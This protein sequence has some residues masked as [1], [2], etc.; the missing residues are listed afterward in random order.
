M[1]TPFKTPDGQQPQTAG[2]PQNL[3]LSRTALLSLATAVVV[4]GIVIYIGIRSR[5]A[6]EADL[7]R[8]TEQA[9]IPSVNVIFPK[10]T[11]SDLEIVLPGNMKAFIDTPIYART[12]GYLKHWYFDI[13]ARVKSGQLLAEIET[14]EIDSQ[15]QQ[16]RAD[17]KTARA[18]FELAKSTAARWQSLVQTNSVSQQETDEKVSDF[19]AKKATLDASVANVQRLEDLQAFQKVYAP[20]DGI[21]TARNTDVGALIDAGANSPGKEL[22]HLAAIDTLRV[23][24]SIPEVYSRAAQTG[25]AA[26]LVL[27]EYPGQVF[28]GTL[29]R[30]SNSIDAVSRTLLAEVDVKNPEGKLLPGAYASVHLKLPKQ[31]PSVTVPVNTLLFRKEGLRVGVVRNGRAGLIPVTIAR[32]F[33]TTVEVISGLQTTD[34]VILDPADSLIDGSPVRVKNPPAEGGSAK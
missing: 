24:V 4:L 31:R 16:A 14:P 18:N 26:S 25:A 7:K 2:P 20:F 29:V 22:F 34:E 30:T 32:D 9:T 21:I 23:Y 33:G 10:P 11:E 17:L 19:N 15:L 28:Q 13:G 6:A 5:A 3:R 8:K 27:E 1:T 12:N